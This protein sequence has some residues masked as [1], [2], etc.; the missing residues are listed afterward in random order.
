VVIK[1]TIKF[2]LLNK[3]YPIQITCSSPMVRTVYITRDF[4]KSI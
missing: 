2:N 1:I 4:C 3:F